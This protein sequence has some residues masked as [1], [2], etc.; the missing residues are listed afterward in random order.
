MDF[1][2]WLEQQSAIPS[3]GGVPTFSANKPWKAKKDEIM[4]FWRALPSDMPLPK[5]RVLPKNFKGKS[6]S[7][8]A[9]R[10]TGSDRFI[11]A[12][13]SKIKDLLTYEN[14]QNRIAVV[15]KQQVNNKTQ[16]PIPNSYVLYLNVKERGTG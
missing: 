16:M 9:L 6:F 3:L 11:N 5:I 7:F 13:L 10:V 4:N 14:D 8:D 12:I 1:K 15:Y 2:N